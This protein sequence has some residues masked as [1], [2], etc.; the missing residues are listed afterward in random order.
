MSKNS[1]ALLGALV[2]IFAVPIFMALTG[3]VVWAASSVELIP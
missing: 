2:T 3:A 1:L